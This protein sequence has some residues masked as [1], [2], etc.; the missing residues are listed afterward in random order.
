M[1]CKE[2]NMNSGKTEKCGEE[3]NA[4]SLEFLSWQVMLVDMFNFPFPRT[5]FMPKI[6]LKQVSL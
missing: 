5:R 6:H 2:V 1:E 4:K 3:N